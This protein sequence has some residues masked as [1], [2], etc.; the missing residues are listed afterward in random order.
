MG[1]VHYQKLLRKWGRDQ[2][3]VKLQP[4]CCVARETRERV[5]AAAVGKP[6]KIM[7]RKK[8]EAREIKHSRPRGQRWIY[9]G[10]KRGGRK[11]QT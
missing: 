11:L 7:G 1:K 4:T 3:C 10:W 9:E 6:K 5:A 8:R 2:R